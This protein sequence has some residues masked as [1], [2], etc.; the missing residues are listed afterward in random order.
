MTVPE[1]LVSPVR[2]AAN[3][4]LVWFLTGVWHDMVLKEKKTEKKMFRYM[5]Y[6]C[7]LV[8]TVKKLSYLKREFKNACDPHQ[9]QDLAGNGRS[10][11]TTH[12]KSVTIQKLVTP[13]RLPKLFYFISCHYPHAVDGDERPSITI[14]ILKR[15]LKLM[16]ITSVHGSTFIF[17][18][19]IGAD[20]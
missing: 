2:I 7:S 12:S 11:I 13:G 18:G 16:R 19:S 20:V 10:F 9:F 17:G 15:I 4:T 1:L 14:Q 6:F 8:L 3:I 5:N